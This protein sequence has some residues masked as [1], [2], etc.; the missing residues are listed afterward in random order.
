M[1][2]KM[3]VTILGVAL[4]SLLTVLYGQSTSDGK[5]HG[6]MDEQTVGQ[7]GSSPD[8]QGNTDMP[9]QGMMG[10]GAMGG[11]MMG[12]GMGSGMG[13]G[14]M[15]GYGMGSMHQMMGGNGMG[16]YGQRGSSGL[17]REKMRAFLDETRE[18]R[19]QIHD[20]RFDYGE[21]KRN[22]AT[23]IGELQQMEAELADLHKQL[24]EQYHN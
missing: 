17:D 19:K 2:K 14:M 16:M 23:T 4:L 7:M 20:L 12:Y 21:K 13:G 1:R 15:Q 6:M 11:P 22:P 9:Y 5:Q 24:W 8:R 18:L 3:L 10:G